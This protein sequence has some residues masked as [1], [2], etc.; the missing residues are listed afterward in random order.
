MGFINEQ[1]EILSQNEITQGFSDLKTEFKDHKK[2]MIISLISNI[3]ISILIVNYL[4][5]Y[6]LYSFQHRDYFEMFNFTYWLSNI[7][8]LLLT[9]VLIIALSYAEFRFYRNA[10]KDTVL[11]K[12][13]NYEASIYGLYGTAHFMTQKEMNEVFDMYK[14]QIHNL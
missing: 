3:I 7:F 4:Y 12:D 5:Q 13:R 14:F 1:E 10:R 6:I 9:I 11:D 8:T 2:R